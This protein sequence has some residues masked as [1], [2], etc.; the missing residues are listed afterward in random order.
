MKNKS[1]VKFAKELSLDYDTRMFPYYWL[2]VDINTMHKDWLSF[3]ILVAHKLQEEASKDKKLKETIYSKKIVINGCPIHTLGC[4]NISLLFKLQLSFLSFAANYPF[5]VST[6][7]GRRQF[8]DWSFKPLFHVEAGD[9]W[10]N[11]GSDKWLL[12]EERYY[13]DEKNNKEDGKPIRLLKKDRWKIDEEFIKLLAEDKKNKN[14]KPRSLLI[15]LDDNPIKSIKG[16]V[17][18]YSPASSDESVKNV[19]E[20]IE[21]NF[22]LPKGSV[23]LCGPDKKPLR[24]GTSIETLR[25]KWS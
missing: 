1:I 25:K 6:N 16:Q 20:A 24:A 23:S 19:R 5:G 13:K 10:I 3:E 18:M 8:V 15:N 22:D 12:Y 14:I 11:Q 4:L 7:L 21:N 9:V 17:K 2:D